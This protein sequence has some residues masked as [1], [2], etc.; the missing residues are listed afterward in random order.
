MLTSS[1]KILD[2]CRRIDVAQHA[3]P[4]QIVERFESQI[5]IDRAGAVSDQQGEM[6]DFPRL[7]RFDDQPDSRARAF[8][9]QMMM[10]GGCRQQRRNGGMLAADAAIGQDDEVIAVGNRCTGLPAQFVEGS[11]Q[12]VGAA[13]RP[14]QHRQRNRLE[15]AC[16]QRAAAASLRRA[17][18][19]PK[20]LEFFVLQNRRLELDLATGLGV[21]FEKIAL[22]ADGGVHRHDDLFANPVHG[23]VSHLREELPK[24]VVEQLWALRKHRQGGVVAH[25][26]DR[27]I[28]VGRHWRHQ[29]AHVL[30]GVA[31][32]L[33]AFENG[34]VIGG[35]DVRRF[36]QILERHQLL[37]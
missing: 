2:R 21:G 6:V 9:N 28:S 16:H 31:E 1:D 27:F 34:L 14:K 12:F 36:R 3:L 13:R 37:L 20:F 17:I 4:D 10:H 29:N 18:E 5:G 33:L 26:A 35:D 8:A 22:A 19:E 7:A 30:G 11:R 32:G 15:A 24:I 25:G 23:R